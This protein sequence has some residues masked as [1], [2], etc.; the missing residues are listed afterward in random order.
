MKYALVETSL[1]CVG[2]QELYWQARRADEWTKDP[3]KL[4]AKKQVSS[5]PCEQ[6]AARDAYLAA[7]FLQQLE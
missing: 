2:P 1:K 7:E 5:Q 6:D 4:T 3:A